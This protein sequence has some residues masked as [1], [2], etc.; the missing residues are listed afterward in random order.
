LIASG[1]LLAACGTPTPDEQFE[2]NHA[3]EMQRKEDTSS[4]LVGETSPTLDLL[5]QTEEV[6][7]VT[8]EVEY[9]DGTV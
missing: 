9:M 7:I 2:E 8:E 4:E 1:L 6:D 5:M 3:Q